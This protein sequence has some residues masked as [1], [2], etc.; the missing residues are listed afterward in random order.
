[1]CDMRNRRLLASLAMSA[2]L[3]AGGLVWLGAPGISGA[4]TSDT[5]MP[6]TTAPAPDEQRPRN[7][8]EKGAERC[9]QGTS[10]RPGGRF[11]RL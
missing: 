2:T 8:P 7:C 1:M 11:V 10:A 5:T 6:T 4:Q 9:A 3:T